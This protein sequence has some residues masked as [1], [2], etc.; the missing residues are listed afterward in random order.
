MQAAKSIPCP[1]TTIENAQQENQLNPNSCTLFDTWF[2]SSS[3]TN[4]TNVLASIDG[5]P[6]FQ[7]ILGISSIEVAMK[8]DYRGDAYP[9]I[10]TKYDVEE[11]VHA[12][13]SLKQ[14]AAMAQFMIVLILQLVMS[15]KLPLLASDYGL[16][17][18]TGVHN[19]MAEYAD[20]LSKQ[21]IPVGI[22]A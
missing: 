22:L 18:K 5:S 13:L 19:F 1:I 2:N 12:F 16:D 7:S 6:A 10:N 20:D 14:A 3:S 8:N 4:S 17:I 21:S 9:Y 15:P 11:H